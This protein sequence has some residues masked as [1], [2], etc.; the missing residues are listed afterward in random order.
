MSK[1]VIGEWKTS[2]IM[3]M[4]NNKLKLLTIASFVLVLLII[5][6]FVWG[7]DHE[8]ITNFDTK[9]I[10]NNDSSIIVQENIL[11]NFGDSERHGIFREIPISYKARGGN[12]KLRISNIS[13]SDENGNT[14]N[15]EVTYPN[16]YI[17]LKIG[18]A[19]KYISGEHT[20]IIEY[21]V[22]RALNYLDS[23]DEIYWNATGN[24]WGVP[25]MNASA[26]IILPK[27]IND[28]ELQSACFIGSYGLD[29][30]CDTIFNR[31]HAYF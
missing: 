26:T 2:N 23:H 11:Y 20:Y 10:I 15:Y 7:A 6:T 8:T 27:E 22:K 5:P 3:S 21:T 28:T 13:V 9:I 14:Y 25:I 31:A 16:E 1:N 4:I 12:Y 29:Y 19:D 18:D 24:E 17:S 30:P